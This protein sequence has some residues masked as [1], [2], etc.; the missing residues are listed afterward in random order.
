MSQALLIGAT[1]AVGRLLLARLLASDRYHRVHVIARGA[2]PFTH[3]K[4]VVY[5]CD[6]D[7]LDALELG[8][9]IDHAFCALGTT[10]KK[11]GSLAAF[12]SVDLD[13]VCAFGA[14][15]KRHGATV[16]SVIS[17][18]GANPES[19]N[20]Y[21]RTK[22]EMERCLVA[23]AWPTL[24]LFRP[25]LLVGPRD[26]F[27]PAERMGQLVLTLLRPLLIGPARRYRPVSTMQVARA[28]ATTAFLDYP[29]VKIFKSDEIADQ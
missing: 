19:R 9:R 17:S 4:L 2:I 27:R 16:L 25:A 20:S 8:V 14:L 21:L 5:P 15:A 23:Q 11:A 24:R 7:R 12:R 6:L 26:E 18:Q 10:R 22:G 28:M 29:V 3:P 1:G 13:G